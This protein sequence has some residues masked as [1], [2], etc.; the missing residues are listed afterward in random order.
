[1][2]NLVKALKEI[3]TM[4]LAHIEQLIRMSQIIKQDSE[5]LSPQPAKETGMQQEQSASQES[6]LNARLS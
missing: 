3:D 2:L 1:L 4:D 5:T 6:P